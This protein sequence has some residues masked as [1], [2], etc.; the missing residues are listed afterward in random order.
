M[1]AKRS[2]TAKQKTRELKKLRAEIAKR[3]HR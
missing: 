1:H 2:D 3:R